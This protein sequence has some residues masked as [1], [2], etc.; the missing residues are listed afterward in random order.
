MLFGVQPG[1]SANDVRGKLQT[2][3]GT[4]TLSSEAIGTG[5]TVTIQS[6]NMTETYSIVIYGDVDGNGR[7]TAVDYVLV[8]NHIM[9]TNRLNGASYKAADVN[10]DGSISAVDYVNIKNYIMGTNNVIQN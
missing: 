4:V 7:I 10:R 6:G 8:K 9:G 1:T 2:N 3:G 5:T